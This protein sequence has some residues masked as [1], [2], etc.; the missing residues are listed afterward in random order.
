MVRIEDP[1]LHPV[2]HQGGD[3]LAEEG[4]EDARNPEIEERA[5]AA[6]PAVTLLALRN[7]APRQNPIPSLFFQKRITSRTRHPYI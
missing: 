7:T 4:G 1:R 2:D 5:A 3:L 6:I